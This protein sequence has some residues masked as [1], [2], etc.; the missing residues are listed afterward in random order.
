MSIIKGR[1]GMLFGL[2]AFGLEAAFGL[3]GLD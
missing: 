1:A 2:S 3:A